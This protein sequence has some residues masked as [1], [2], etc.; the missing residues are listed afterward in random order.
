MAIVVALFLSVILTAMTLM[1]ISVNSSGS[2]R[3]RI[4]K[5]NNYTKKM[6]EIS[7]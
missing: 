4:V 5:V 2:S 3:R 7:K 1:Q 6:L